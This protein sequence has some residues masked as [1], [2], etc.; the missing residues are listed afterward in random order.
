MDDHVNLKSTSIPLT[1]RDREILFALIRIYIDQAKP[2]SSGVLAEVATIRSCASTI[3]IVFSHLESMGMVSK[4]Y[5]SSGRVPTDLGYRY[6]AN[7]YLTHSALH[8]RIKGIIR[9]SFARHTGNPS[10]LP[11]YVSSLLA[12][13][14]SYVG[15]TMIPRSQDEIVES[16]RLRFLGTRCFLIS[17]L[18]TSGRIFQ[19][20]IELDIPVSNED[21][22][23]I[24]EFLNLRFHG[25]S[26][27]SIRQRV[28]TVMHESKERYRLIL[29]RLVIL[30]E[31]FLNGEGTVDYHIEGTNQM[32]QQPDF[33][34]VKQLH[35]LYQVF[36][37][38]GRVMQI[39]D[40]CLEK[41]H[42]WVRIGDDIPHPGFHGLSIIAARYRI[43]DLAMGTL[44]V[45]GPK[46]MPYSKVISLVN[47]MAETLT[48][49]LK[50]VAH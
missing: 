24:S 16:I 11:A 13:H 18:T 28:L 7:W 27:G 4:P 36:E 41:R 46:R 25:V 38:S 2:V 1:R 14:T 5:H 3:R 6:F 21:L 8:P 49:H 26:L 15:L 42:L 35:E 50:S 45:I 19:R 47:Y 34:D 30:S 9:Q 43:H 33:D 40:G 31:T 37:Q 32:L 39:L 44:G 23:R 48:Q 29:R 20:P 12:Q 17:V 10:A 22:S